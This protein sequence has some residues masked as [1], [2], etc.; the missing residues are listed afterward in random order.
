MVVQDLRRR[1]Q[2]RSVRA[3]EAACFDKEVSCQLIHGHGRSLQLWQL[4]PSRP[5]QTCHQL[6]LL[7]QLQWRKRNPVVKLGFR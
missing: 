7:S 3:G 6:C 5:H 1:P 4:R 2:G